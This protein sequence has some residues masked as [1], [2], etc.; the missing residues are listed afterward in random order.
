MSMADTTFHDLSV[1]NPGSATHP[2]TWTEFHLGVVNCTFN[3]ITDNVLPRAPEDK[4]RT[5]SAQK[6][7]ARYAP[8]IYFAGSLI[9]RASGCDVYRIDREKFSAVNDNPAMG[10]PEPILGCYRYDIDNVRRKRHTAPRAP[11]G[12]N[13]EAVQRLYNRRLARIVPQDWRIGPYMTRLLV[14]NDEEHKHAYVYKADITWRLSKCLHHPAR[15]FDEPNLF[16]SISWVEVLFKPYDTFSKGIILHLVGVEHAPALRAVPDVRLAGQKRK[17]G[18]TE[19]H[20]E[21]DLESPRRGRTSSLI[22]RLD[23]W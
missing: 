1:V 20:S 3:Q 19:E 10:L 21:S 13:N 2:M 15:T 8:T 14:T 11:R 17:L 16:P 18:E 4:A 12:M 7:A 6:L 9:H 5:E 22:E 23:L